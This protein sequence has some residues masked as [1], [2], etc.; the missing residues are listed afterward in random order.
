MF[1]STSFRLIS[2]LQLSSI[3]F[4]YTKSYS[5]CADGPTLP[6]FIEFHSSVCWESAKQSL[7]VRLQV[8]EF[9][10][11]LDCPVC[12][13]VMSYSRSSHSPGQPL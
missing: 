8:L 2:M 5:V 4:D 7:E 11:F 3:N 1:F 9:G 12:S 10:V 6:R 13:L